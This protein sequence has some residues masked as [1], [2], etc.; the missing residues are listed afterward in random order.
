MFSRNV[1]KPRMALFLDETI[2]LN[3]KTPL[4]NNVIIPESDRFVPFALTIR[5]GET[6]TWTNNDG[7]AHTV[8]SDDVVN[9]IGP[10][11]I[12]QII[13]VGQKFTLRFDEIGQWVYFCRFH[14]H[15]D[16]FGQPVAPGC[17]ENGNEVSGI[18]GPFTCGTQTVL[19]NFGTP[20]MGVITILP[21][22]KKEDRCR[23]KEDKNEPCKC[24]SECRCKDPKKEEEKKE[25]KREEPKKEEKKER[26]RKEQH[27]HRE[28]KCKWEHNDWDCRKH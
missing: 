16:E 3:E 8:V 7:D 21:R 22:E 14:A 2:K 24:G 27:C 20:M 15:L 9:Q 4:R 11:N 23:C 12:N 28:E 17:G 10:R 5:K 19:N 25:E 13:P 6:V 18:S 26:C 1:S